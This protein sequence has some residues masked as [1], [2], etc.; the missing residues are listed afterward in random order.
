MI[1]GS[2]LMARRAPIPGRPPL[3]PSEPQA[4]VSLWAMRLRN[5]PR[6]IQNRF[7]LKIQE[8]LENAANLGSVFFV[9]SIKRIAM[10]WLFI[11]LKSSI[12]Y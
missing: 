6:T 7:I 2:W 4:R 9:N 8:N 12:D 10:Q 11:N 3:H 1:R 5:E